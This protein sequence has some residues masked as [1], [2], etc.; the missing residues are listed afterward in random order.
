MNDARAAR[1]PSKLLDAWAALA[2]LRDQPPAS[3]T[4]ET[5][6]RQART[7]KI[8]LIMSV[9]NLGEVFYITAKTQ[10]L[11]SAELILEEMQQMPLEVHPAP[12]GLVI[13]AAR[14]KGRHAISYADAFAL[15]TAVREKACVVTGDPEL[16]HLVGAGLAEI[17]WIG[18]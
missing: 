17:E 15:A 14:L 4:V 18:R 5:L 11:E 6:W 2:W 10:G 9:V 1:S 3:D 8:R 16:K 7:G 12:N 13:E